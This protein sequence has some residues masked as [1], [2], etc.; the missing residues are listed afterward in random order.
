MYVCVSQ[1]FCLSDSV[2]L[3]VFLSVSVSVSACL[4]ICLS[5][6]VSLSRKLGPLLQMSDSILAAASRSCVG[7]GLYEVFLVGHPVDV[8]LE[9][10]FDDLIGW[11]GT[12]LRSNPMSDGCVGVLCEA[13]LR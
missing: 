8:R 5:V 2:R 11:V 13:L 10:L 7:E 4:S 6:S 3:S 1:S 12:D 9:V